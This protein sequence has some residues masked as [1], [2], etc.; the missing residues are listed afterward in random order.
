MTTQAVLKILQIGLS[1]NPGGIENC[2]LNYY[3]HIDRT[4]IQFDFVDIYGNGLAYSDEIKKFGGRIFTLKNFKKNPVSFIFSLNDILKKNNYSIVHIN[5]LSSANILPALISCYH[6]GI[7]VILHSHNSNMPRGFC[8]KILHYLNIFVLRNLRAQQWACGEQAG[9]WMFGKKFNRENI[10]PNAIDTELFKPDINIRNSI[11]NQLS[12]SSKDIVIGFVG[13][14]CEQKNVLFLPDILKQIHKKSLNYKML[15]IGDGALKQQF[16]QKIKDFKLNEYVCFAGVKDKV[17]EYYN[18]MDIF[19]LPS[20]FEGFPIVAI[21]A[22]AAGLHCFLSDKISK[23][24]DIS[25]KVDFLQINQGAEIWANSILKA[26]TIREN[27]A[28]VEY[29][30]NYAVKNLEKK[31]QLQIIR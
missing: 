13:R 9:V 16:M 8:R 23:E 7:R 29:D 5:M 10:I 22:Q 19:V 4:K 25:K 2:I 28:S 18:A 11:R 12:F 3:R 15:I 17:F 31:Y 20:L 21:E 14:L 6:K 1:A 26:Q 27:F 30:I 24:V